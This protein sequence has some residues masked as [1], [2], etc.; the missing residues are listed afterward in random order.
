[1]SAAPTPTSRLL[2]SSRRDPAR[3]NRKG[4]VSAILSDLL[5]C[6]LHSFVDGEGH[7]DSVKIAPR[8]HGCH[9]LAVDMR[10]IHC[11]R[12]FVDIVQYLL[13]KLHFLY[14]LLLLLQ[15]FYGDKLRKL[16]LLDHGTLVS[17]R[18]VCL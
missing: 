18:W 8:E 4:R 9:G 7:V 10:E 5:L 13:D 3:N 1:M 6:F 15:Y 16:N 17:I 12:V 11:C 14:R 2:P